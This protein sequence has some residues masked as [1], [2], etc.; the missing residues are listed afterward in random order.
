MSI[1]YAVLSPDGCF[2]VGKTDD[3]ERR[4]AEHM[5]KTDKEVNPWIQLHGFKS[6]TV[7]VQN[8]QDPL[9]EDIQTLRLMKKYGID[10]VRGG[11]L[12]MLTIN[13]SVIKLIEDIIEDDRT[14]NCWISDLRYFL[15]MGRERSDVN[16]IT[17]HNKNRNKNTIQWKV[18]H[19]FICT[20]KDLC[21]K[22]DSSDHK[23]CECDVEYSFG[24]SIEKDPALKLICYDCYKP[25]PTYHYRCDGCYEKYRKTSFEV[26]KREE[27]DRK[28]NEYKM[29]KESLS[30]PDL[31]KINDWI[32]SSL[33]VTKQIN[34]LQRQLELAKGDNVSKEFRY[35]IY[36]KTPI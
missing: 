29:N 20:A 35:Y 24:Y 27:Q 32:S 15:L 11:S 28:F 30:Y 14:F 26:I 21:F 3:F 36:P 18:F 34:I 1:I 7:L 25:V 23:A 33:S 10:S 9:E 22:C 5:G 2:Y 4:K 31:K 19:L 17:C 6:M 13:K 12:T 8:S 16:I